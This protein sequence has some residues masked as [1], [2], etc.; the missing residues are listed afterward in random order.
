[1]PL[2]PGFNTTSLPANDDG[3][4]GF[5]SLTGAFGADGLNFYG[6]VYSGLFVNNNGNVTFNAG[7]SAYTPFGIGASYQGN[8]IIAAFLADVDTRGAGSALTTYGFGAYAGHNAFGVTWAGVGYYSGHVDKLNSFQLILVDRDDQGAGAFDIYLNYTQITWETGDA[9][10]GVNGFG[11][12]SAA[13]GFSAGTAAP[14]TYFEFSGSRVVGSFLDTGPLS[15][16]SGTNSDQAG[17][18]YFQ[19]R[20]GVI[21]GGGFSNGG[22]Q[23]DPITPERPVAFNVLPIGVMPEGNEGQVTYFTV[24]IT[25][26]GPDLNAG[27]SATWRITTDDPS[28]LTPDQ[29]L[30]GTVFFEPFQTRATVTVAIQGDNLF[31]GDDWFHFYIDE[32]R[33][34]DLVWQPGIHTV[35]VILND[36]PAAVFSFAGPVMQPEGLIGSSPME[37]VVLRTGDLTREY[38][39][40]W[41]LENG[42]TD[43]LDFAPDQATSGVVTFAPGQSQAVIRINVQGDVRIEPDETFTLRLVSATTDAT[44]TTLDVS[45]TGTIL[46]DDARQTLLVASPSA[47][48]LPEGDSG[49]TAFNISVMRVGDLSAAADIAYTINLP[50]VGGLSPDEIQTAL[51]GT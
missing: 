12:T 46:D 2:A 49:T 8:P 48:V 39:V 33:Y 20:G 43:S 23:S 24:V 30:G 4:T 14:G 7:S 37:F 29:P 42:T 32:V 21:S 3:S 18:Y 11:G 26:D 10:G 31:E 25:R 40:G 17:Q 38:T 19:V 22:G 36:D 34:N 47:L 28:D 41:T 6:Q 35:G 44:T 5:I 13:V 1:M 16:V 27:S 15:L 51:Q 50:A 9:S 45:T